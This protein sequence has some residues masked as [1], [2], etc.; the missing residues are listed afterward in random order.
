MT[1][2]SR[3]STLLRRKRRLQ[4]QHV[5]GGIRLPAFK[6]ASL[7]SRIM[8]AP[9]PP[10]LT[11]PLQQHQGEAAQLIVKVGDHVLKY[12]TLAEGDG[13]KSVSIHAPSSGTVIGI[14]ESVIATISGQT[15]PCIHLATDGRD[16]AAE[17]RPL[18]DYRS[19]SPL[20]LLQKITDAGICGMGG[21]GFPTAEK[22][23]ISVERKVE[24]LIINAV[25][26]EPYISADQALIRE[27][28]PSVVAG[29]EICQ[30]IC[31]AR[32]C[33]IAIGD[34]KT[35][36]I[37]ALE[38]ALA[39]S[40]V[41]LLLLK[42]KYTAGAERQLI[43][44]VTGN[45]VPHG[46]LPADIGVLLQNTGTAHAI[47]KAIVKGEP[48]IS[49]ITTVTGSA[50]QTP[51][52]FIAL[53][54][55]PATFLFGLCG[56][57][58]AA[59]SKSIAGGNLMGIELHDDSAPVMKT[60]NCLIAATPREFPAAGAE[61]ACIRC[62][63]CAEVCPATLLPQQLLAYAKTEDHHQLQDH[64]LFDCIECGACAYVCPSQIP[65]VQYYRASKTRIRARQSSHHRSA[66]WQQRFQLHQYRMKKEQDI[67]ADR[68]PGSPAS[69]TNKVNTE[70]FSREQAR[71]E[72]SAA[73][74]RVQARRT[75]KIASSK[76]KGPHRPADK[77]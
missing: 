70:S 50:L 15:Q 24:L 39:G 53:L 26:C 4:P 1:L 51:K 46:M 60:T 21:A 74:A 76:T 27:F 34:D 16:E 7:R 59:H 42:S 33:I 55:T 63:F 72:I 69:Q 41:E 44:A 68:K 38:E 6:N 30:Q 23:R 75:N 22:L 17:I 64:G 54:G 11:L 5:A 31:Q 28:A 32:R 48:C 62:G 13:Y 2:L 8:P 35:D 67:A 29:A 12:Q 19:L 65:L 37:A 36:S 73:V 77:E 52:N 14:E 20:E 58:A 18:Q 61:L 40:T 10:L 25:E 9:I 3:L 47:Y 49:R 45:E 56:I 71:Q 43:Q 66:G 57:D